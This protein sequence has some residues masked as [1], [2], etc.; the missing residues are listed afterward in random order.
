MKEDYVSPG[1]WVESVLARVGVDTTN[2]GDIDTWTGWARIKE[3]YDYTEGFAKQ[4][5]KIPAGMNL[6]DLPSGY[7]FGFEFKTIQTT[8]NGV[9]PVI[10]KITMIF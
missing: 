5:S 1:P 10:D 6:S 9:L 7:G 4:I 8:D 2:N 3:M